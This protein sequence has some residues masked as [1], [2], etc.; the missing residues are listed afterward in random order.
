LSGLIG[1][2]RSVPAERFADLVGMAP[3]DREP[4]TPAD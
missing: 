4:F 1:L 3:T 2:S